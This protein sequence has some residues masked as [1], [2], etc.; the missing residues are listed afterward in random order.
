MSELT[1]GTLVLH[2]SLGMGRVVAVEPDA[3]HVFFPESAKRFAAKLRWPLAKPML[4]TEGLEPDPWL[5]GLTSFALDEASG[6][7]ALNGNWLTHDQAVAD[8]LERTPGG[9]AAS[10]RTARWRSAR[11]GWVELLGGGKGEAL[12][13]A[14]DVGEIVS[15]LRKV[16]R[17]VAAVAGVVEGGALELALAD[18]ALTGP[19]LEALFELL[20][21]PS[22][23]RARFDKLFAAT[24]ALPAPAGTAWTLA[25]L[26]PFLADPEKHV[27][28]R[29]K[30]TRGAAER[31]GCDIR[32]DAA[33]NWATYA[34][35]RSVAGKLLERL[36]VIGARDQADVET[37]LHGLSVRRPAGRA[38]AE[39]AAAPRA[40]RAPRAKAAR[41]AGRPRGKARAEG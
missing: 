38:E 14:G 16:E 8:F 7:Y 3:I 15:R 26:F 28:L 24:A 37:F 5:E 41:A 17:L 13:A 35:L 1:R 23:S 12:L 19:W 25:T 6:R 36:Q 29:P 32:Y 20:S 30:A 27:L 21:V 9:F 39:S 2:T 22:P 33:P 18:P 10:G 40:P 4:R 34:T 11:E 31:L